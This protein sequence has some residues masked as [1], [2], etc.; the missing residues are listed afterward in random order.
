M[1]TGVSSRSPGQKEKKK[2]TF[3]CSSEQAFT[4]S[5]LAVLRELRRMSA[6]CD[7]GSRDDCCPVI[8]NCWK[9]RGIHALLVGAVVVFADLWAQTLEAD[10][11]SPIAV[12]AVVATVSWVS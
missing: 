3:F 9:S 10:R 2:K 4:K 6:Y 7:W 8:P 12:D 1:W 5:I 11:I